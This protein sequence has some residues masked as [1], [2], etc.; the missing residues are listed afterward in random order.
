MVC[1]QSHIYILQLDSKNN[2]VTTM[3]IKNNQIRNILFTLNNPAVDLVHP[4][5]WKDDIVLF[6]TY[7]LERDEG[8]GTLHLQGYIELKRKMRPST[9]VVH[10]PF[11]RGSHFEKRMGT[12]AQAVAY[13]NNEVTREPDGG[14][15]TFGEPR[16]RC[17]VTDPDN[18]SDV[19]Y[20]QLPS[21]SD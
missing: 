21:G 5:A 18:I 6:A 13:C 9:L 10:H 7:Q 4:L 12:Q 20:Q 19:D 17:D 3:Y 11:L 2:K 8:N 16:Q 1:D 14:P 15:F